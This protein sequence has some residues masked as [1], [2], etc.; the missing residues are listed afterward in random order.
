[1]PAWLRR[2]LLIVV[3]IAVV[4]TTLYLL[5]NH[6]PLR[7][8][9]S[10]PLTPL[11][12]AVP[13]LVWTVWPYLALIASQATLPLLIRS[14]DVIIRLARAYA[15][16]IPTLFLT[17]LLLPT[18]Y[19]RP[20]EPGPDGFNETVYR[21]LI[22]IDSPHCCCPSGHIVGPVLVFWGLW[23][24]RGRGTWLLT[25]FVIG[26]VSILTTKQH[27][28]WD[29]LAGLALAAVCLAATAER[30]RVKSLQ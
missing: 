23:L 27:Y 26:A 13:F 21:L 3:P 9:Q 2:N 6:F 22:A 16:A 15:L 12:E 18:T 14:K 1:M 8:P 10:L 11:D 29:L 5:L 19:P 20:P 24:D 17:F 25:A 28:L 30:R 4:Q 7:E